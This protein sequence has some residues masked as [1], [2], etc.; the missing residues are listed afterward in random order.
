[1]VYDGKD[2]NLS[3]YGRLYTWYVATDSRN[4]CPDGWHVPSKTEWTTLV[5]YNGGMAPAGLKLREAGT[6]HFYS[7]TDA[8]NESGFTALPGGAR[9]LDGTFWGLGHAGVFWTN[10]PI[11]SGNLSYTVVIYGDRANIGYSLHGF[12]NAH[13][14]RCIKD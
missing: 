3:V 1:L 4:I 11:I 13:S 6:S 2:N 12:Y 5:D 14:I 8:T 10:G 9:I 7:N